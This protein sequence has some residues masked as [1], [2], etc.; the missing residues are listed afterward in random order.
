[1]LCLLLPR[2]PR[3]SQVYAVS[4]S[5]RPQ[6]EPSVSRADN[7][8]DLSEG[9]PPS[10]HILTAIQKQDFL[11]LSCVYCAQDMFPNALRIILL[12]NIQLLQKPVTL[13]PPF[14]SAFLQGH[15]KAGYH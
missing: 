5:A 9:F 14:L 12:G 11:T 10:L 7:P 6:S 2:C 4:M 3:L 8:S 1:M 15:N 13:K